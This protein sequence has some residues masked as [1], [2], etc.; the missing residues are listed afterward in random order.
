MTLSRCSGILLHVTSL[1]GRHGVGSL[2]RSA[3][4]WLDFLADAGQKIWQVLPLGPTSYGDSPYQSLSTFAG[5]PYLISLEALQ[6]EG[7]CQAE[8]LKELPEGKVDYHH[9]YDWKLPLLHKIAERIPSTPEFERFCQQQKWLPDYALFLALKTEFNNQAWNQWPKPLRHRHPKALAEARQRHAVTIR[10]E[11]I[12]QWLFSKQWEQLR[13]YARK[14]GIQ[15]FG[16]IPIFVA[17]DSAD[18]WCSPQLF[19]FNKDLQPTAVAGVPPDYFS[20]TG[21]LWGNP[22]YDWKSHKAEGYAWWIERVQAAFRLY[23]ILRV[24]HFRGF[25]GYW[26][27]PADAK[28]AEKGR[29]VKGPGTDLFK[30]LLKKVSQPIVAEDLG[31]ITPDVLALRDRFQLPGMKV[32]QFAFGSTPEN[33]F[34]PH[35][36]ESTQFVAYTGTHDNDTARG[37]YEKGTPEEQKYARDYFGNIDE[38]IS[39][40]LIRATLQSVAKVAIVPLQDVLDLDSEARMNFPGRAHD[41]WQWRLL[42]NQLTQ[43]HRDQLKSWNRMFSR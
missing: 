26:R 20:P 9:L 27:V 29:W 5:N 22:L 23:D 13:S 11:M 43:V 32:L 37:W 36:F 8:E 35:N 33:P 24:D 21:Q 28:T 19:Q 31:D 30:I 41:N 16:D 15:I 4:A 6:E 2:N 17:M 18:T 7:W 12:I 34:L 39:Q 10:R 38:P 40:T 3:Y 1:P 14:R 42:P 25:A